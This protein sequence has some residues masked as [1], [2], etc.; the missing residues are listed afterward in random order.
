MCPH[1]GKDFCPMP[2]PPPPQQVPEEDEGGAA[3][4][5]GSLAPGSRM[6]SASDAADSG[7]AVTAP[8]AAVAPTVAAGAGASADR[9]DDGS[10]AAGET[11]DNDNAESAANRE[12]DDD[13]DDDSPRPLSMWLSQGRF[14]P[15]RPEPPLMPVMKPDIV[16]FGQDLPEVFYETLPADCRECDL[17]IVIGSSLKVCART[18]LPTH[19]LA[20]GHAHLLLRTRLPAHQSSR[21]VA[22]PRHSL[23][24]PDMAPFAVPF[25]HVQPSAAHTPAHIHTLL[26]PSLPCR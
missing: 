25:G 9:R 23:I 14:L 21:T 19:P 10:R 4:A 8:T 17:V 3:P 12:D 13:D 22:A 16:F 1:A 15:F 6:L 5:G 20:C 26:V 24:I 18:H 11:G 7:Q 2:P